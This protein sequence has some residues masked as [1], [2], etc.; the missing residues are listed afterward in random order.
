MSHRGTESEFEFTLID[1]LE[2]LHYR[3]PLAGTDCPRGVVL[4]DVLH[5]SLKRRLSDCRSALAER[6]DHQRPLGDT[7]RRNMAFHQMLT[8]GS[9]LIVE[10]PDGADGRTSIAISI[11]DWN[12]PRKRLL[13]RQPVCRSRQTTPPDLIIFVMLP[14]FC[15]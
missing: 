8:C 3:P 12:N 6:N 10:F 14:L 4:K 7:L 2:Q 9:K 15:L 1:R 11:G 13:R 5:D